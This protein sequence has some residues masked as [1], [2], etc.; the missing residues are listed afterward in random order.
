M[1]S[2]YSYTIRY[3]RLL[4]KLTPSIDYEEFCLV[5][6][7]FEPLFFYYS[8]LLGSAQEIPNKLKLLIFTVH[9]FN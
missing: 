5:S 4:S 9:F 7:D 6:S 1:Y 3:A 8:A 2:T